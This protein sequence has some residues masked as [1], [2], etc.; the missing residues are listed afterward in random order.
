ML[1]FL[2]TCDFDD[3]SIYVSASTAPGFAPVH[4]EFELDK[5]EQHYKRVNISWIV[6]DG[7]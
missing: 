5:S 2:D 4:V 3:Y 1:F 7:K 6:P